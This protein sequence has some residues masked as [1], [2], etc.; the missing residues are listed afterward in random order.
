MMAEKKQSGALSCRKN[1]VTGTASLRCAVTRTDPAH[2]YAGG[3]FAY[4]SLVLGDGMA[5][6]RCGTAGTGSPTVR[7]VTSSES[8]PPLQSSL[9]VFRA[10]NTVPFL[11][12]ARSHVVATTVERVVAPRF[13]AVS[14]GS[15][16]ASREQDP[17]WRLPCVHT[18]WARMVGY[19]RDSA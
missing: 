14:R 18:P 6:R 12:P 1:K 9:H 19:V 15:W 11:R 8:P 3:I 7:R 16:C 4:M 13:D 2:T 5:N 10:V 17:C